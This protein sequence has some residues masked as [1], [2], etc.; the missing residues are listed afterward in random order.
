MV[1]GLV[2]VSSDTTQLWHMWLGFSKQVELQVEDSQ[3]VQ[4]G[5]QAQPILDNHGSDFDDDPQEEQETSIAAGRQRRQIR[6]SQRYGFAD[7]VAC[8]LRVAKD[9]VVQ[10]YST[11][12]EAVTSSKS[13]FWVVDMNHTWDLEKLPEDAKT[14][15]LRRSL[16]SLEQSPGQR[17]KRFVYCGKFSYGSFV[18]LVLLLKACLRLRD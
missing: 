3:R 12:P 4:D 6:L 8:A 9:T 13:A 2:D 18:C 1:T 15:G 17:Y 11:L 10:E 5:T 16:Y 7:L 14:V